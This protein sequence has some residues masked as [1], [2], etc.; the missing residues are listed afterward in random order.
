MGEFVGI[1]EELI[2]DNGDKKN[3]A[4]SYNQKDGFFLFFNQKEKAQTNQK[5]SDDK[6][7]KQYETRDV[8]LCP[9]R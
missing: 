3:A 2:E 6:F 7:R 5:Q 8:G 1:R 9:Q 4:E